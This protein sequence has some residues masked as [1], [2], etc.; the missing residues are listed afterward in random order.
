MTIPEASPQASASMFW[1]GPIANWAPIFV[2]TRFATARYI[3]TPDHI[4]ISLVSR[5]AQRIFVAG[6][7]FSLAEGEAIHIENSHEIQHRGV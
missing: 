3:D 7:S 6:H 4:E 2:L 1:K 5:I